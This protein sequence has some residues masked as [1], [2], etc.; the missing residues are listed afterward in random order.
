[1]GR[2]IA[3]GCEIPKEWVDEYNDLTIKLKTK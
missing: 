1:M 2:Y 3:A